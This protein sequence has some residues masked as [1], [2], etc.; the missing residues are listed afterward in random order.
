MM[1]GRQYLRAAWVVVGVITLLF[2]VGAVYVRSQ[3]LQRSKPVARQMFEAELYRT[4]TCIVT[5]ITVLEPSPIRDAVTEF[6]VVEGGADPMNGRT[7]SPKC[8]IRVIE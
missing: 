7:Q 6:Y 3:Q 8:Y 2:L 5:R 1:T 4:R